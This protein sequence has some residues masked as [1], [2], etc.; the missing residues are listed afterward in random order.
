[1]AVTAQQQ[2][3]KALHESLKNMPVAPWEKIVAKFA[4]NKK[5]ASISRDVI[6]AAFLNENRDLAPES[7]AVNAAMTPERIRK[8]LGKED[9]DSKKYAIAM[10]V[11][12]RPPSGQAANA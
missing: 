4:K 12:E 3:N 7:K 1:M 2:R 5:V 10:S 11:G 8:T 9:A 6:F